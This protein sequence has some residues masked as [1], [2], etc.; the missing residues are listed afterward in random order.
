MN[1][2][3]R[4]INLWESGEQKIAWV[5]GNMPLLRRIEAEFA[6]TK[7]FAGKRIALS[8]RLN[9]EGGS[10]KSGRSYHGQT[11]HSENTARNNRSGSL[12]EKGQREKTVGNTAMADAF[13]RLKK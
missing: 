6:E 3:I 8:M 11:S 1:S 9:E 13:A 2:E 5:K 12:K 10:G 7:P 4:D